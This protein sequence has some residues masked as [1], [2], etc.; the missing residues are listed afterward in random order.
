LIIKILLLYLQS[1]TITNPTKQDV[2]DSKRS[3]Q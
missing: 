3:V 2:C 1:K